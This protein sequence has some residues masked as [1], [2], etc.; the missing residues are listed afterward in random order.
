MKNIIDLKRKGGI[1]LKAQLKV[2]DKS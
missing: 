2:L 1:N